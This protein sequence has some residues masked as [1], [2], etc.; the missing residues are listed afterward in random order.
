MVRCASSDSKFS[1]MNP[2]QADKECP[3]T[4]ATVQATSQ[5]RVQ[6]EE[7]DNIAEINKN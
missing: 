5:P 6:V 4:I 2:E 1:I 3:H 7:R